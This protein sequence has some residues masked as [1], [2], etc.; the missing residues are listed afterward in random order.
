M[1]QGAGGLKFSKGYRFCVKDLRSF[2]KL[3][4]TRGGFQVTA[5]WF[6][7]DGVGVGKKRVTGDGH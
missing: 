5:W 1:R 4:M 2:D 7:D 6:W 3:R